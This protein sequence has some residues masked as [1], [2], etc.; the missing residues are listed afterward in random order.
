M[1]VFQYQA[2][3]EPLPFDAPPAL[4]V[5]IDWLVQHPGALAS[6]R[7]LRHL[8]A[9]TA[10]EALTAPT[11][12]AGINVTTDM[13]WSSQYPGPSF[14]ERNAQAFL[15][16]T[17]LIVA[18]AP[19]IIAVTD[20]DREPV[21]YTVSHDFRDV[22]PRTRKALQ[23]M[24][25]ILNGL[26]YSGELRGTINQPVLGYVPDDIQDWGIDQPPN[27]IKEALDAL[28]ARIKALE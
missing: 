23:Q 15:A 25:T 12:F 9:V 11:F 26:L 4:E 24:S 20:P 22:A 21:Q 19:P 1:S 27:T 14:T 13:G 16:V 17:S 7:P 6:D 5:I 18:Q 10:S 3:A 2:L 8:L 28:A